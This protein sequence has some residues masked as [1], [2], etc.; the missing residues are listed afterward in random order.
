MSL[1]ERVEEVVNNEIRPYLMADGGNIVV[2]DV[3]ENEGIVK[4]KLMG[5]CY[6]CPMA[7]ITLSAFVE[8]HLKSRIPEVK[9]VVPV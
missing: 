5:A 8:Q 1:K 3:D 7:Q 9:K 2:V 6:G 4:V